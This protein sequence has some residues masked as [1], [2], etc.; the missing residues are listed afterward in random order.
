MRVENKFI[1]PIYNKLDFP[2]RFLYSHLPFLSQILF[3]KLY[4]SDFKALDE[5]YEQM[6]Q[7]APDFKKFIKDKVCLELGPGNSY[8]NAYN[9]LLDGAKKVILVDKFP[10]LFPKIQIGII[11]KSA[12]FIL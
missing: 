10:S 1:E 7:F 6:K 3:W 11:L 5:K 8:I 9:L 2:I 4:S 12:N